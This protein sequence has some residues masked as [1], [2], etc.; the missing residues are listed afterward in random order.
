M[1]HMPVEGQNILIVEDN[2]D[3]AELIYRCFADRGMEKEL[4]RVSDGEQA[5]QYMLGEGRYADRTQYPL[6]GLVLLDLR[7]P[8][9]DGLEVL[10][11]IKETE[12]I[13]HIPVVML[14][15]STN[16]K[17]LMRAYQSFVN[18]YLVKPLEYDDFVRLMEDLGGYWIEL[19]QPPT[20]SS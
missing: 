15:S 4:R 6:P 7:L 3:H 20:G 13:R 9:V 5:V 17:D 10:R 19:N 14:T 18:S 1:M 8:K 12:N 16:E 11:I 2:D